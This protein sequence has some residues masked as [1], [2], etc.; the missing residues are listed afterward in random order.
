MKLSGDVDPSAVVCA[1]RTEQEAWF[2]FE[3][4][5]RG[6]AA[7][8]ALGEVVRLNGAGKERF[9]SMADRWRRLAA[10][11]V[12]DPS[13]IPTVPGRW[14]WAGSRLRRK[15]GGSPAWEGFEP[16]SMIVPEVAIR[17]AARKRDRDD[18]EPDVRL[19]LAALIAPR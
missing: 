15:G 8:A 4:P 12:G 6:K 14:R 9:A 3:Q 2:A 19:T 16:A 17:R 10:S 18:G 5:D 1:S 11:A 13:T 7:L